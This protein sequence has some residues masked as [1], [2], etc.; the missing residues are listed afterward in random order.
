MRQNR[1]ALL[2]HLLLLHDVCSAKLPTDAKT[3]LVSTIGKSVCQCDSECVQMH[4]SVSSK[5]CS[6]KS[7]PGAA[8]KSGDQFQLAPK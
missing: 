1:E 6:I 3:D 4:L 7:E 8:M 2:L 5:T